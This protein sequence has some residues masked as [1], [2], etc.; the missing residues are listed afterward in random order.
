MPVLSQ[1]EWLKRSTGRDTADEQAEQMAGHLDDGPGAP[2]APEAR[3]PRPAAARARM[4][5]YGTSRHTTRAMG[6]RPDRSQHGMNTREPSAGSEAGVPSFPAP[7]PGTHNYPVSPAADEPPVLDVGPAAPFYAAGMAHGVP[8]PPVHGGRPAPAADEQLQALA[9]RVTDQETGRELNAVPVFMVT[10][11]AGSRPGRRSVVTHRNVPAAGGDPFRLVT[12]D[13][14]RNRV[15]ILNE[16]TNIV[17]ITA[18][19]LAQPAV[20][21]GYGAML[22][23]SMV[24]YLPIYT[25]DELWAYCEPGTSGTAQVSI[26]SEYDV[27]KGG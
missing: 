21:P 11:G 5:A 10:K 13:P 8:A 27:P 4:P 19:P 25:Q 23:A 16:S 20:A 12:R 2:P 1:R 14:H 9:V 26:I 22:P 24:S 6:L 15:L 17:R 3:E 7:L 18:D